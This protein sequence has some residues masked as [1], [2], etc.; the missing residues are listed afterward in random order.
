M[1][2]NY[3][4]IFDRHFAPYLVRENEEST[5]K[6]NTICPAVDIFLK[7]GEYYFMID[8]PGVAKDKLNLKIEDN[9]IKIDASVSKEDKALKTIHTEKSY[10]KDFFRMVKVPANADIAKIKANLKDGVLQIILP[11]SETTKPKKIEVM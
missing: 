6:Q 1:R 5:T 8:L 9:H 3:L 11:L 10:G 4:K 7:D 2:E